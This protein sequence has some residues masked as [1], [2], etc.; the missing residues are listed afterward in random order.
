[1]KIFVVGSGSFAA[2]GLTVLLQNKG[3]EVWSLNRRPER[4][5][6]ERGLA[7]SLAGTAEY[8]AQLEGCDVAIN[9]LLMKDA[10]LQQNLLFLEQLNLL[11]REIKCRRF[12]HISSVSVL[13]PVNGT[14]TEKDEPPGD[15]RQKGGYARLKMATEHWVTDNVSHCELV[16]VR[17]GFVVAPGLLDPIVGMG[18]LLPTQKLLGLGHRRSIIPTIDRQILNESI[19][20]L[21][22]LRLDKQRTTVMLVDPES[23]TR[24][25]YLDYCCSRFGL[26]R[27]T[28]FLPPWIWRI[29]LAVASLAVSALKREW[30]NLPAKFSHNLRLRQYDSRE[31][32]RLLDLDLHRDWRQLFADALAFQS[33]N[34][35]LPTLFV[36]HSSWGD[37]KP[38]EGIFY[39]GMG[40]IALD[41]HLPALSRLGRQGLIDWFD[42]FVDSIPA[43]ALLK[44]RRVPSVE[45]FAGGKAV[46]TT[47]VAPRL[48]LLAQLPDTVSEVLFEKPFAINAPQ[49]AELEAA[50]GPKKGYVVHNYRF[51][52]NTQRAF[53]YLVTHNPGELRETRLH[54]DSPAVDLDKAA[55]MREERLARTLV[56]DYAIHFLDLAWLFAE[57]AAQI[58][59]L[60]V[61]RNLKEQTV[62]VSAT[63]KF[64]NHISRVFLR[65]GARQRRCQIEYVF[66]NYT[67]VLRFFP[68]TVAAVHGQYTFVD[69]LRCAFA[70]AASTGRKI[71]EKLGVTTQEPSHERVL[72]AFLGHYSRSNIECLSV[73]ALR[74]FYSRLFALAEMVYGDE[75]T[76]ASSDHFAFPPLLKPA[77]VLN[78]AI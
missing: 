5:L 69:D 43:K 20:R 74:P 9:Y 55:W 54:F 26:A 62:L 70:G 76:P 13:A 78:G 27:G 48:G 71:A 6:G 12:I 35:L 3:H 2:Q 31:T 32:A 17:P 10:S 57:G 11:L 41:R 59:D 46:I 47:P 29:S 38:E 21:C 24:E 45:Q 19:A 49:F 34:F 37:L 66:S 14:V 36:E 67:L 22:A 51:K 68:D 72:G 53:Q 73:E 42:P 61:R 50:L 30:N 33:P 23:P 63:V 56:I 8:A 75:E 60:E 1:M 7:G 15:F 64:T 44:S 28:M 16:I 18:K 77:P 65:Q 58:K 52:P 25:H 40:R 39:L 4:I